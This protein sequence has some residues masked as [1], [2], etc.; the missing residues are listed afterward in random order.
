MKSKFLCLVPLITVSACV[1][2][3]DHAGLASSEPNFSPQAFF[4]GR[5]EGQGV[6]TSIFGQSRRVAVHGVGSVAP[7][8]TITLD[9]SVE[10][11]GKAP[12]R[13]RWVLRPAG[14]DRFLGTLTDAQGPVEAE[15]RG[16]RMNIRFEMNDG[17]AVEQWIYLQPGGQTALNRMNVSKF[18]VLVAA[19]EESIRRHP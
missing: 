12:R 15:V 1:A 10:Q 6:L 7:D 17:L 19:L 9:Q 2:A 4:E 16:N 13:R 18:G 3:S 11:E 5:T 8:G 14:P